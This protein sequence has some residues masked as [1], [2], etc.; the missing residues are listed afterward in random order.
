MFSLRSKKE[1]DRLHQ[2]NKPARAARKHDD[3]PSLNSSDEEDSDSE[4]ALSARSSDEELEE[5]PSSEEE[6]NGSAPSS[7]S[8]AEMPYEQLPRKRRPSWDDEDETRTKKIKGLPI[9]L[10]DG[11]IRKSTKVLVMSDSEQSSEEETDEEPL[12]REPETKVEDVATGARFGRAAVVDIIGKSSRRERVEVAK[13]QIAGIC[14][15]ILA[16]PENSVGGFY[17]S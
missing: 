17:S 4:D 16:E 8:D 1:L 14:Q 5:I 13:E 11:T 2:L 3:L 10:P 6:P 15:E 7:D 9:K 12:P